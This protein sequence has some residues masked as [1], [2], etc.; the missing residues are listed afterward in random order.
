MKIYTKAGDNGRS[1][2]LSRT[3]LPKNSPIFELLGT[4]DELNSFL[5][6]AKGKTTEGISKI[7]EKLQQ[8]LISLSGEV[9]GA[10]K[11]ASKEEI[12]S[13]EKSIDSV[14]EAVPEFSG[15]V[16]PGET[17]AGALLDVCRTVARRAERAAV[18]AQTRGGITKETLAWLNRLSDLLYLLARLCDALPH[19]KSSNKTAAAVPLSATVD[20]FCN[21][22]ESLCRKVREYAR[23]KGVRVVAAVCDAGGNQVC[24]QREDDAFVA[25]VD[26]AV[27]KA[28]TSAGLKMSTKEVGRLSQPG[29]PL[30]GIQHTNNGRIV[31]FGGGEPLVKNGAIV[32]ALGVSGG[33][34]EQDTAFAEYGAAYFE[35]EM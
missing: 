2:T 27:N 4:L 19:E 16:L 29:E 31:I 9:A 20:G 10:K 11:F 17:E 26:I 33:T 1:S 8:N 34:A 35:K 18:A 13:L 21:L 32:G 22:A 3:A 24:M 30:Y 6:L 28:F 5:G 14:S 12:D 25:S 7:V 15:F 23:S